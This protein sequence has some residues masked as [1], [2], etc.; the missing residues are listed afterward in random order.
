VKFVG[1]GVPL[2]KNGIETTDE[3]SISRGISGKIRKVK[4]RTARE[5]QVSGRTGEGSRQDGKERES[6]REAAI[7]CNG[8]IRD[9]DEP[10]D[11]GGAGDG[12][13]GWTFSVRFSEF[14][15]CAC[16]WNSASSNNLCAF[17]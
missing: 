15:E 1:E 3:S 17:M 13:H 12:V 6:D 14:F 11:A 2:G 10:A 4:T 9:C 7:V 8:R 5:K 16:C